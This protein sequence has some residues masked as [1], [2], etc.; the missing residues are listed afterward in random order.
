MASYRGATIKTHSVLK[1]AWTWVD[2]ACAWI[3]VG[4]CVA[5]GTLAIGAGV[6]MAFGGPD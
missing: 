3:V 1:P 6:A 4:T 2:I 5:I